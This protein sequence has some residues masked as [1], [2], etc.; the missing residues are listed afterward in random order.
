MSAARWRS[1][2]MSP[3]NRTPL[4]HRVKALT[5]THHGQLRHQARFNLVQQGRILYSH[6]AAQSHRMSLRV[7]GNWQVGTCCSS[8]CL[9]HSTRLKKVN[10][11]QYELNISLLLHP[12]PIILII[13]YAVHDT[14]PCISHILLV[15]IS[16]PAFKS[17]VDSV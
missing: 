6:S 17:G 5:G 10:H 16:P 9:D 14:L 13:H 15:F 7:R 12:C 8:V 3:S 11:Y 4:S 1:S 2:M